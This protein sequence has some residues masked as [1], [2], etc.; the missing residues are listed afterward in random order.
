MSAPNETGPDELALEELP[1][2]PE[3][4]L[5]AWEKIEASQIQPRM[6]RALR[7]LA[8][9]MSLRK[10]AESEGYKTKASI[11]RYAQKHGLISMTDK[12]LVNQFRRTAYKSLDEIEH[13][14]TE[15]PDS[16]SVKD[17]AVIAGISADKIAKKE[18][19]GDRLPEENLGDCI[20]EIAEI[21]V[22]RGGKLGLTIEGPP[23]AVSDP[24]ASARDVT[25]RSGNGSLTARPVPFPGKWDQ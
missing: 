5:E 4:N 7:R 13:R 24:V 25:P 6:K 11:F 22:R 10:A 20:I 1:E 3:E 21:V 23:I 16:V 19:W 12:A 2:I 18:R 8:A 9:G 14:I 17:L 15:D